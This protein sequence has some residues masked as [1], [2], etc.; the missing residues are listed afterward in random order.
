MAQMFPEWITQK[1]RAEN[2]KFRAEFKVYDALQE[3]LSDEWYVFYSRTWTWVESGARIRTREAD[4][5]IA[6]PT[7]GILLMEVKGGGIRVREGRW[8]STDRYGNEWEINPYEQVAIATSKLERRLNEEKPNPFKGYRFSTAVCFPDIEISA[9]GKH[10]THKLR[11]VTIDAEGTKEFQYR[12]T[13]IMK[14]DRGQFDPPGVSRILMLK[15]LVAASWE[16]YAPRWIQIRDTEDEIKYLTENQFKLLY[17]LA[18]TAK[19]LVVTGCAGSGK[20]MLAAEVARRMVNLHHKRVL[21]TCYNRNL[22]SWIRTSSFFVDN[23]QMLVSNFHKLCADFATAAGLIIP[24]IE[25]E[26]LPKNHPLFVYQYPEFLLEAGSQ[27]YQGFDA[28][29][30][31]EAQDF[32][33]NWWIPLLLM[34]TEGGSIH[35]YLDTR[36]Q[37]WGPTNRLPA[38]ITDGAS[39]ITLTENVRNTPSIHSLAMKFHPSR[40]EGYSALVKA[41]IEPQ[42]VPIRNGKNERQT[43]QEVIE[44]L[45]HDDGV[46]PHDIAILTPL[47]IVEG[48]SMWVPDKTLLG[49]YRLVHKLNPSPMEIFCSSIGA[50]K[51]LE[52]PVL[53]LTELYAPA[54]TQEIDDYPAQLYVGISRARSQ[55]IVIS[56]EPTFKRFCSE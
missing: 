23:G 14:D 15:E 45:I 19:R 47:S 5:I 24:R 40:G 13:E 39:Y 6:H 55:L 30:V 17:Q 26:L 49:K 12:I 54:V 52:F 38:E 56:D 7:C 29:I 53:I 37:L 3:S 41:N 32:L 20:T 48:N 1:Q 21:L 18:P 34:L 42:F 35:V 4:F 33:E 28:I 25:Q 44:Q 10:L 50:A 43:V 9:L 2:P 16:I 36:Q 46:S 31:D 51:G 11:R 22:A 8:F 27:Q